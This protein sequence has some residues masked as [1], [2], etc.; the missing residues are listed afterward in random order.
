MSDALSNPT[1]LPETNRNR[2]KTFGTF[3]TVVLLS[4]PL[5]VIMSVGYRALFALEAWALNAPYPPEEL[6]F[7]QPGKIFAAILW[8]YVMCAVPVLVTAVTLAWRTW[9]RGTFS[10]VYAAT[11]AG[12]AMAIYMAMVAF[13]YRHELM[14][15]VTPET[16]ISGVAYAMSISLFITVLLRWTRWLS[17]PQ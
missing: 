16:A 2:V 6:E 3:A 1:T 9:K 5:G 4:A 17:R 13:I 12:I 14:S 8:T 11:V 10:Y 7:L 15:V